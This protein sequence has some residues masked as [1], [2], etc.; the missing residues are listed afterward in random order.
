MLCTVA[1]VA[2]VAH[3][4]VLRK[5]F[6]SSSRVL[7]KLAGPHEQDH[8]RY[9][10]GFYAAIHFSASSTAS[11]NACPNVGSTEEQRSSRPDDAAPPFFHLLP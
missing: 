5:R 7:P 4:H 10:P 8:R 1:S 2:T 11:C 9:T 3:S 6:Q